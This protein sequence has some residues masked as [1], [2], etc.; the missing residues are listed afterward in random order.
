MNTRP[1]ILFYVQHLLGIGHLMR[2]GTLT[3]ALEANGFE[4]TLVSGGTAVPGFVSGATRFEQLSPTRA[5][6]KFFKV[7]VDKHNQQIDDVWKAARTAQL[8][9]IFAQT[10]PDIVMIEL[11]PFG[12]RQMR[13]E[14]E[15]LLNAAR[16]AGTPRPLIVSSVRDILVE[17]GKPERVDEMVERVRRYFDLVLIHGDRS[18]IA[19]DKT[20]PRMSEITDI[21]R[22][23]GYVADVSLPRD[24]KGPGAGEVIV[25]TGGGAVSDDMLQAA[26]D[27][28]AASSLSD[29]PWRVLV[30]HNL[31][32]AEF[33]AYRDSA[34]DGVTVER[35]R[36]DFRQ[37]LSNC[38]LSISQGGYNTVMEVLAAGTRA[39]CIPYA[40]GLESE[41]TLRCSLLTEKGALEIVE[42]GAVTA[43][44]V[45]RAI[46]RAMARPDRISAPVDMAGAENTA[47]MLRQALNQHRNIENG[48]ETGEMVV[49]PDA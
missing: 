30:G 18:F 15:P 48:T 4:V 6:D 1:K 24:A 13:F 38:T 7:L 39:V 40:G 46:A 9:G 17:P 43:E 49:N 16:T 25:S 20:F 44:N 10:Q 19:F 5:T 32:E 27:S 23:T 14:I 37:L 42:P 47:A 28:R 22:Y 36:P 12:R 41:Q 3:R 34:P 35:S 26:I 8:C 2:A 11:F 31:P 29:T 33:A 21:S 45:A